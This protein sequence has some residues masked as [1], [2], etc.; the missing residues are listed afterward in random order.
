MA[1]LSSTQIFGNLVVDGEIINKAT[2]TTEGVVQLNDATNSTSTTQAATANAVKKAYD[3]AAGK[4]ASSHTH[5][6][7]GSSS[8]GGA[9]TSALACT[10]NSAT[11]T[12]L[13]TAR[14]INGTAFD[15]TGAIT[16]A[17]WGTART[18]T[19]GNTGKSVNGS[20]NVSWSLSEI[21]AA[22]AGF[23][24]GTTCQDK[25]GQDCNNILVTGFYRGSNMTNK[26]SGCT[27][28]WIYLLVMSHDNSS[29]VR[30]VAYDYGTANQVYTRVKQTGTWTAWVATDTNTWRGVQDNLTST[31]TDQSLSANQGKVLKGLIDGKAN[32]SHTHKLIDLNSEIFS[33][34]NDLNTYNSSKT[35]VAR[36]LATTTNRPGDYYTVANFG[37]SSNS[38]FQLA[39]SYGNS[40][41]LYVRGRHDTSGNYTPWAKVYTDKNKPTPAEIGALSTTGKAADSDK[42]DGIDSTGFGRAY[43]AS[44][45]F[46]GNQNGI[47]TAQ[48][49]TLITNLGA[50][51]T[52]YWV[53]RGSWSYASNQIINDTGCGNIHLAGSVVEVIGNSSAYTIRITTPTTSS[54]GATNTE[55]IYINNGSNYNPGWRRIYNM[56]VNSSGDIYLEY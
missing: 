26:P 34:G 54:G 8:A 44:V 29:W 42:L 6:Y 36:T 33:G 46:G 39:H 38:N 37:A 17:N 14:T 55:F 15:G 51:K 56:T 23:G 19:V 53:A 25:S 47:T 1:K 27:Q 30:Q 2:T 9:A 28:G 43:G 32:S 49:I 21:G 16:T 4:A 45:N 50:F 12:K 52:C 41:T 24:L 22:P 20:G 35:W 13:Q 10:G 31:A 40:S 11:A 3:L 7:A 48:F 5:N 18:L